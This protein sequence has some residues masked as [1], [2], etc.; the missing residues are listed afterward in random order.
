M[1]DD[2]PK[3]IINCG[4]PSGIG[5]DL[6]VF[7]AEKLFNASITILANKEAL[8]QRAGLHGKKL[9]F[10]ENVSLHKGDGRLYV[11]N[12]DY[13]NDVIPGLPNKNNSKA[14]MQ[15]ID[16]AVKECMAM[17][18]D[19]LVTL[20]ISKEI[21]S[22]SGNKFTGHTEYIAK[23][24]NTKNQEVMMLVHNKLRVALATTHIPLSDVP[25]TIT[26]EKL[27]K[28]I[29]TLHN[30]L[31]TKFKVLSPRITV[32][33]LNPHAGENGEFGNEELTVLIPTINKL[34]GQG[35]NLVGPIP[36][37]TAFTPGHIKKT[38][39]FLAMFHD[40]GLAPFKAL[41]FGKGV[42]VTLGL[43][44]IRTSVDHGT[45]FNIVGSKEIDPSSFYEA[46]FTA[47]ELSA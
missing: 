4:D 8:V 16:Y 14:Q 3:I 23:L 32:T 11:K 2:L 46:I 31:K 9:V 34:N 6:I 28:I 47:I 30:D 27:E 35:C 21:L 22:D 41:S 36:A 42:N 10:Q 12:I 37:D 25:K 24:S 45:A 40:Q 7:L 29:L 44:F 13:E 43:P 19:A 5:L 20:P 18:Y 26:R 33:G 1:G 38:D 39:A 17:N 15:M